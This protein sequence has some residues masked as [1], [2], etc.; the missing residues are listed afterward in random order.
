[1]SAECSI[2]LGHPQK[3]HDGRYNLLCTGLCP[4]HS[5][6]QACV[7]ESLSEEQPST[8]HLGTANQQ[9]RYLPYFFTCYLHFPD[10]DQ[11]GTV[12]VLSDVAQVILPICTTYLRNTFFLKIKIA[13]IIFDL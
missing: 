11:E 6:C 12:C 10:N 2:F 8:Q 13:F 4:H 7:L 5:H 3:P 1:M 9:E